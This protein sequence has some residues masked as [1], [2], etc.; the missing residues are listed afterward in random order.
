MPI[1]WLRHRSAL[2]S[3]LIFPWFSALPSAP[4]EA[5]APVV[6]VDAG[7]A[8]DTQ[9]AMPAPEERMV[10]PGVVLEEIPKGSALEKAGLQVGDVILRWERLP[11][12]PANPEV[13]KGEL[14]SY[15]DWLELEVEQ[16][17]RGA[18]VLRG[19]RGGEPLELRVEPGGWE[20]K[21]RPVLPRVLEEIY[22]AGKAHITSRNI[23]AAVRVWRSIAESVVGEGGGDLRAWVALRIGDAWGEQA[24]WKKAINASSEALGVSQNPLAKI[25]VWEALGRENSNQNDYKAAEIAYRLA[26]VN[27]RSRSLRA[28]TRLTD[29]GEVA[30]D[31]GNLTMAHDLFSQALEI[32]E[33][34]S[35]G[36]LLAARILNNLGVEAHLRG[37]L[38]LAQDLFL[39]VLKIREKLNPQSSQV[40]RSLNNLG[41]LARVASEFG[42]AFEYFVRALKIQEA[43]DPGSLDMA[44]ILNNLG[45]LLWSRGTLDSGYEYYRRALEI[46]ERLAPGSLTLATSLNNMGG[47]LMARGELDQ[48]YS[49]F[50]R[51]LDIEQKL[52][53]NSLNLADTLDNL[54]LLFHARG[55]LNRAQGHFRRA[56]QIK[57]KL[58]P[59]SLT[60]AAT[61]NNLAFL[62][63]KNGDLDYAYRLYRRALRIKERLA[64][65]SL[66]TAISLAN[67]GSV[68]RAR[69]ELGPAHDY[70]S[71][72]LEA[73]EHQVSKLGSSYSVQGGFRAKHSDY[74]HE[75]L[76]LL[77][78]QGQFSE[79][80][81]VLERFRAQTFLTMLAERDTAFTADIPVELDRERRRLGVKYDRTLKKLSDLNPRDHGEKIEAIRRELQ[82]LDEEAGGIEARIRQASPRLAALQ[83]PHALGKVE[84]QQALDQGTL[85]L[86]Y[87]VGKEK[88]TLFVLSRLRDLEVKIL[89]LGEEALRSQVKQL[90]GLIREA[91]QDSSLGKLRQRRIQAA[92]YKLYAALLGP[93]TERIAA[94][95]RL[96]ILPDGPL[97]TLPF[98][99]LVRDDGADGTADSGQYLAEWKPIHV[100]LSATAFAEL[101]QRRRPASENESPIQLIAF[102]DPIYPQSPTKA[103]EISEADLPAAAGVIAQVSAP[104]GD[105]TVRSAAERGVFDWPPLPYTRHEVEGIASLFPALT[106]HIFLG[107][108]AL[109]EKIKS[110]DPKTRI[111][112]LAAHGYTDEHL[113]SNSFV[114]LT[115]PEDAN[116]EAGAP[117]RDNGLLQVWEIFERVRL[118]ADLVVLSACDTGLGEEQGGEGLIGLT[119]AF[120]YAGARTVMASLWSVQDQATSELMIR[121][122]KY[123]R[124]GLTKDEALRRAQ[125]ELIRGPI[126]VVDEKGQK[127]L[128]DASAP[129]FW[130]GFQMYG[131]WQ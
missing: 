80:L 44:R 66:D 34:S 43:L 7:V 27:G 65:Q 126:E 2:A 48:A 111:L 73:L 58:A 98:A 9:T 87:S 97:H 83:Y 26:L 102:G 69:S 54:G 42:D 14:T 15:F 6:A 19:R 82:K 55:E 35:P 106:A 76:D 11:N 86:S 91:V 113:P 100:A 122:Y 105:P 107:P 29:L 119:R 81:H 94:S 1:A 129:Y 68:A 99:A 115:I 36:S 8:G 33:E 114:A 47:V 30:G 10:L 103:K 95:E 128:F 18:V 112:H 109:E 89:P 57:D 32:S 101:R 21:V 125:M 20:A 75:M 16:V 72:A 4:L 61:L 25:A 70:Y 124:A 123:L 52:A 77:L 84:A 50:R 131:D 64:P 59:E 78:A 3:I 31:R 110:L 92:S 71:R 53:P 67:L 22:L 79:A 120:Q 118:D 17:P 127:S 39:R 12:P 117:E 28:A 40:A 38:S 90:L 37:K 96:L 24:E 62:V 104:R 5:Q 23:D 41:V 116:T 121:F 46:R 60:S 56:L 63:Q 51:A 45:E 130:A 74:Y 108:E 49:S 88:T 85:L 93:V 13:A